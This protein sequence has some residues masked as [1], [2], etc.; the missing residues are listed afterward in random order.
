VEVAKLYRLIPETT[1]NVLVPYDPEAFDRLAQQARQ[2]GLSA[3]W[4]RDARAHVVSVYRPRPQDVIRSFLEPIALRGQPTD[5][6]F[7]YTEPSHYDP[8]LG[9]QPQQAPELWIL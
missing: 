8:L 4:I 1:V 6:W 2:R 7:I 5:D 3:R 9:L